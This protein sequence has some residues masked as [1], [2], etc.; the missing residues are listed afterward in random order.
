MTAKIWSFASYN[1]WSLFSPPIG[2]EIWHCD[3]K[4]GFIKA[5]KNDAIVQELMAQDTSW[6]RIGLLGQQGVYEFHQDRDLLCSSYGVE[7]VAKILQLHQETVEIATRVIEILKNYYENPILRGKDIIK[8]SRG[9][10]G[11]PEPILIQQGNYQFN[12]YAAIDCIFRELDGTLH[13]LDFKTGKTDFD[14][15]Q[16]LVYL[17]AVQYLYPKQPAI[18][19]FYNL[20]TNK[21]SEHITANPNQLKAI[22][23]EL[24]KIAKQHQQELWRYRKNPAE[25]NQIYPSNPG[26]N[27]LYCQFKS[28]CKFFISEVS[29]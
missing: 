26:I 15:R 18:A 14:R 20:E 23:T 19:S 27:C 8:L 16:G 11:Y 24:V 1:L 7:Q 29:A 21:W 3:H 10:E 28:I 9:D 17:L 22:Q 6:Q 4:R 25:F 5:K 12:L 13:I 2:Q